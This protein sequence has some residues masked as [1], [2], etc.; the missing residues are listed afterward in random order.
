MVSKRG[1]LFREGLWEDDIRTDF[2]WQVEAE[3][4]SNLS[5]WIEF[6]MG[7]LD[8][9]NN[10]ISVFTQLLRKFSTFFHLNIGNTPQQY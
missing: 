2:K 3:E 10:D 6:K 7:T 8:G 9:K 4:F 1:E 5:L